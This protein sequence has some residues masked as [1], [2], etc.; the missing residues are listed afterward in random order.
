MKRFFACLLAVLLVTACCPGT[1]AA[2]GEEVTL[3]VTYAG[4]PE[5]NPILRP[6]YG[7]SLFDGTAYTY[8][9]DLAY[10]SFCLSLASFSAD[11]SHWG[12]AGAE[13]GSTAE[14]RYQNLQDAY[15][16]M[17]FEHTAF[18]HYGNS[19]ND[20]SH[21]AAFALGTKPLPDGRTLVAVTVRSGNY[22][23]E[24]SSNFCLGDGEKHEGF[25]LASRELCRRVEG[26]LAAI[27]GE[28]VLWITGYSRGAAVA[29]LAGAYFHR[30]GILPGE[31]IYAY[32]FGCPATVKESAVDGETDYNHIFN[33]N[34]PHD[35]VAGVI[36]AGW[37]YTRYGVTV[38]FDS[39]A[40]AKAAVRQAYLRVT[41]GESLSAETLDGYFQAGKSAEA[42][43]GSLFPTVKSAEKFYPV[44]MTYGEFSQYKVL[45]TGLW[46]NAT[47]REFRKLLEER[48]GV[49][50]PFAYVESF[51][52]LEIFGEEFLA[53][54]T[55]PEGQEQLHLF[56]TVCEI[57]GVE[58]LDLLALLLRMPAGAELG[59]MEAVA[60]MHH[61]SLYLAW[62]TLGE[63]PF[64]GD[65][66]GDGKVNTADYVLLKRAVLG[67]H[68]PGDSA[69]SAYDVTLD[70]KI[71][72]ADYAI[73]KRVVLGTHTF[74]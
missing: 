12:E 29:N 27:E 6:V 26:T 61:S 14:S 37:G 64:R 66:N 5:G 17:G 69:R 9:R 16:Q 11:V 30:E 72:V 34:A 53:F 15:E 8:S 59:D 21:K 63:L 71:N 28:A 31:Q 4:A 73:L 35:A 56:L 65:V 67:T 18:Y 40:S 57:H 50:V 10:L 1:M 52:S 68:V 43:L 42:L 33:L 2:S 51:G 58:L 22:G 48:H 3:R 46:R 54:A 41:G 7:D 44:L 70:G 23:G 45:D 55:T 38:T 19:L 39:D 60:G 47:E 36:P 25:D 13:D 20:T 24:W 32:T 62:L 49:K 74:Q